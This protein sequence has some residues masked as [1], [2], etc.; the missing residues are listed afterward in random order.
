MEHVNDE[1]VLIESMDAFQDKCMSTAQYPGKA[2]TEG[3]VYTAMGLANEGGEVLGK[4]KKL[5]R[6]NPDGLDA[7]YND[8]ETLN[9][10]AAE[11]GDV[12]WYCMALLDELNFSAGWAAVNVLRKLADRAERGAIQGSGDSR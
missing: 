6:D 1:G 4:L 9:A 10:V 5:M 8:P 11:V 3:L 12:L 7:V 2:T